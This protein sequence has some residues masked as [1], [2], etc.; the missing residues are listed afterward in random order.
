MARFKVHY[1]KRLYQDHQLPP[2]N[3]IIEELSNLKHQPDSYRSATRKM[4]QERNQIKFV[5][6]FAENF[7]WHDNLPQNSYIHQSP[8]WFEFW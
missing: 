1:T 4:T 3:V 7:K 6:K 5:N 8:H 2:I